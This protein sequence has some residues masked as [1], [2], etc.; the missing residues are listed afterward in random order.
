MK[1]FKYLMCALLMLPILSCEL[2]PTSKKEYPILQSVENTLWYSYDVKE[3]IYYDIVFE[4]E[5]GSIT[6]FSDED[7]KNEIAKVLF[8]YTFTPAKYVDNIYVDPIVKLS[9]DSG[10]YYG[11]YI[12][13]KGEF[14]IN[15]QDVYIIQLYE[16]DAEGNVIYDIGGN[17]KSTFMM[18]KD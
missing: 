9:L 2:E 7:R 18:W 15:N 16:T 8:T 5:T 4:K 14:Q 17:Y 13:P 1:L 12:I 11:G 10:I 6:G 3:S